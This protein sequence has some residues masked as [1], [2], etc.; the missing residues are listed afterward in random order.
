LLAGK[1]MSR[2]N[3]QAAADLALE[4]AKTYQ[5]NG[6]KVRMAKQAIVTAFTRAGGLA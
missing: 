6:F 2:E 4:G 3:F 1:P 5:Y